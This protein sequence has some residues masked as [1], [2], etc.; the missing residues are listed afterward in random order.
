MRTHKDSTQD[1]RAISRRAFLKAGAIVGAATLAPLEIVFPHAASV[2]D[3]ATAATTP[4]ITK[5]V[6]QLPIPAVAPK[7]ATQPY[8]GADYYEITMQ[9][10]QWPL[11]SPQL[12]PAT[13]WGYRASGSGVAGNLVV[14]GVPANYLGPTIEA[15]QGK[16]VVVKYINKLPSTFPIPGAIDPTIMGNTPATTYPIGRAVPHLHGGFTPPQFDGH[17][18]AWWTATGQT[19]PESHYGTL[20]GAILN[21]GEAIFWY[22]NQ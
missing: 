21:Q 13:V 15:T 8:A 5:F 10:D 22:S 19:D 1:G 6:T 20:P 12:G 14:A 3:A 18:H 9:A 11:F 2:A 16:P 4:T 7:A 17:P